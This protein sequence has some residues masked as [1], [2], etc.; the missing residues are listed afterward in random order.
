MSDNEKRE[1]ENSILEEECD[2]ITIK[3]KLIDVINSHVKVC[4]ELYKLEAYVELINNDLCKMISKLNNVDC[5]I[6]DMRKTLCDSI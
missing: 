6:D 3:K 4:N 5:L 1:E 2:V